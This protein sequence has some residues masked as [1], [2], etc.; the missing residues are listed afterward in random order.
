[1]IN[2]THATDTDLH[3]TADRWL[4]QSGIHTHPL[5]TEWHLC[6]VDAFSDG[7]YEVGGAHWHPQQI[8]AHWQQQPAL[9]HHTGKVVYACGFAAPTLAQVQA[10]YG[11]PQVRAWLRFNGVFYYSQPYLNDTQFARHEGYFEAHEYEVSQTL[12]PDN[13]LIVEVDCPEEPDKV[14]KR[15]LTGVFSHWD[16]FDVT[17]N[18]GGIWLPVDLH[19]TGAVRL[20]TVRCYTISASTQIAQIGYALDLDSLPTGSIVLR[21]TLT[22]RT[23]QD[24]VQVIEQSRRVRPGKHTLR[25][26]FKIRNPR[27]WWTH[28]LG[29]PDLYTIRLEVLY[30]GHISDVQ[31]FVFGVRQFEMRN[32]IP[33]LN[34][35]RFLAKGNNY[36]PGDVRIATMDLARCREDLRLATECHMNMLRVHAH[37]DHPAFYQAANEAGILLWQDMPLQWLYH[38]TILPEAKRQAQ[39]MVRQLYNHPAVGLWCMH[40]EAWFLTDTNDETLLTRLRT[41]ASVFL[42]S[43]NRDVMDSQLK[44]L[45][46]RE[47]SSRP[48][49]RSSG[50]IAIPYLRSGTDAHAYFG[51]YRNYG[52][53]ADLEKGMRLLPINLRFPTEFGAQ[54][55]PNL[56]SSQRFMPAELGEIDFDYLNQYHSFQGDIMANWIPWRSATTLQ[57]LIDMSQQYQ[58]FINRH[59]TDLLRYHKYRPT[60][61]ILPFMFVDSYPAVLW[62]LIDYWRV[63][64]TSYYAMQMAF[65]PQYAFT[66]LAA[67]TYQLAESIEL[68]IYAVNDAHYAVYDLTLHAILRDPDGAELAHLRH[69]LSLEADCMTREVD[70][71]RLTATRRGRFTLEIT[72]QGGDHDTRQVYDIVVGEGQPAAVKR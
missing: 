71:L 11:M 41:Y 58:S 7:H 17:A 65:R 68:P 63:P 5:P 43:W 22:P 66:L 16:C 23:F 45:A 38:A 36:A 72:L 62:S 10:E 48:V 30:D 32:W 20:Q 18:P 52:T 37:I 9:R 27:L 55:L 15:M 14:R 49:V 53:L 47:D 6:P 2:T 70:R 61:G 60:G 8:P 31:E 34:G 50:E 40:N 39:A 21:W 12:Q 44:R 29:R 4:L 51:W 25:G 35:I 54:S 56:A 64:K 33:H 42:F 57:E 28:D 3:E 46:L 67:R 59:F 26:I 69:R 24:S 19:Y 13:R 1:M